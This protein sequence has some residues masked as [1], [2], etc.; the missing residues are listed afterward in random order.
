MAVCV[1]AV[2]ALSGKPD[3][4]LVKPFGKPNGFEG[5]SALINSR[6]VACPGETACTCEVLSVFRVRNLMYDAVR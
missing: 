6:Y 4:R 2:N 1:L 3:G 5:A